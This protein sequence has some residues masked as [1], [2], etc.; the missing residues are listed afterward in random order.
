MCVQAERLFHDPNLDVYLTGPL[1][2]RDA[3][4][5]EAL[6]D[7]DENERDAFKRS[8]TATTYA[9]FSDAQSYLS[10]SS[11]QSSLS[12]DVKVP[13]SP[14]QLPPA[15]TALPHAAPSVGDATDPS[16]RPH[17]G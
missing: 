6:A 7:L 16:V 3:H 14:T 17:L 15:S 9:D 2:P 10:A 5:L 1:L 11:R 13:A 12:G 4:E 8:V